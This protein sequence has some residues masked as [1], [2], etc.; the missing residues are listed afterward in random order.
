MLR[1]VRGG[2]DGRL[3]FWFDLFVVV[4]WALINRSIGNECVYMYM[5]MFVFTCAIAWSFTLDM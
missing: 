5:Y 4:V 3:L 2:E 1:A